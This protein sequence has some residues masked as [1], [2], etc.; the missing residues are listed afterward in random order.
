MT[1]TTFHIDSHQI[2]FEN[3]IFSKEKVILDG[4]EKSSRYSFIGTK[5]KFKIE[6]K[7]SQ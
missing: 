1:E 4:E 5:H 3:S 7:I 6:V 2:K